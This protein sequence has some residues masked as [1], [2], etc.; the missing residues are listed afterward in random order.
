MD[1]NVIL[2]RLLDKY[3]NSK[4]LSQ[5]GV[6]N[7]RVMLRI[8]KKEFPEYRYED[9]SVRDACNQLAI[10]LE[11]KGWVTLEWV[12]NR[13]VISAIALR[14]DHVMECYRQTGRT[15][16]RALAGMVGKQ[17]GESLAE[18]STPWIAA[19]RDS[20]CKEAEDLMKVGGY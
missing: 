13:P 18:A 14:L 12:K 7:R 11:Q 5:P 3:E 17:I 10:E 15:H 9:A 20:V 16:P 4:H 1:Q 6:S 2:S 8:E 19:W